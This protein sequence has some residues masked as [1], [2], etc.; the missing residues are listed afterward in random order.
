MSKNK[1]G[2]E[3]YLEEVKGLNLHEAR[4]ASSKIEYL[5][6]FK[7]IIL[8]LKK[9]F[10]LKN[11]PMSNEEVITLVLDQKMTIKSSKAFDDL[12]LFIAA[13][14]DPEIFNIDNLMSDWKNAGL[15]FML[16]DQ[17]SGN[18]PIQIAIKT[19]NIGF[20]KKLSDNGVKID[21]LNK[22]GF[23][24]FHILVEKVRTGDLKENVVK[25]W[26][27]HKLP[28]NTL[29]SYQTTAFDN[30]TVDLKN[31]SLMKILAEAGA[32]VDRLDSNG[33]NLLHKTLLNNNEKDVIKVLKLGANPNVA[34]AKNISPILL[35]DNSIK[36]KIA[37]AISE[38]NKNSST[39]DYDE[40]FSNQ[41]LESLTF[42]YEISKEDK[43][44]QE[45]FANYIKNKNLINKTDSKLLI[46]EFHILSEYLE[47]SKKYSPEETLKLLAN[48]KTKISDN[49][50]DGLL[51][52]IANNV[53]KENELKYLLKTFTDS[54]RKFSELYNK[55]SPIHYATIV[56]NV[57]FLKIAL[58]LGANLSTRDAEGMT[59]IHT[60]VFMSTKDEKFIEIIKQWV[61]FGLSFDVTDKNGY[62]AYQ[63]AV[64]LD[65]K[66][67]VDIFDNAPKINT[68]L[69]SADHL[70]ESVLSYYYKKYNIKYSG[71]YKD[72]DYKDSKHDMLIHYLVHNS[73]ANGGKFPNNI[74]ESFIK[75][76]IPTS[77][78]AKTFSNNDAASLTALNLLFALAKNSDNIG[79]DSSSFD[80]LIVSFAKCGVGSMNMDN[81]TTVL[82]Y[83]VAFNRE[84]LIYKLK[85]IKEVDFNKLDQSE[86]PAIAQAL[87]QCKENLVKALT[88][89]GADLNLQPNK[90]DPTLLH[91]LIENNMIDSIKLAIKYGATI[92]NKSIE[93]AKTYGL[94]NLVNEE[95]LKKHE[96]LNDEK[97]KLLKEIHE[98]QNKI[99]KEYLE[100]VLKNINS[101][102]SEKYDNKKLD[103]LLKSFDNLSI[104][105]VE[106]LGD[107]T[108]F[109]S[110]F[111][112]E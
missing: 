47:K 88:E 59:A 53:T 7:I 86:S 91:L 77:T 24:P 76:G 103:D 97:K 74:I 58:E 79:R 38:Y 31:Y 20:I 75:K 5:D 85:N 26:I 30:L 15:D 105:E 49:T 28:I 44:L 41:N 101:G 80:D 48:K 62:S 50:F 10:S 109:N 29:S 56:K 100:F 64:T 107:K 43:L 3:K 42:T 8:Y 36:I 89:N 69:L 22:D 46:L 99:S 37:K 90:N 67:V 112:E 40:I 14:I 102:F 92:D 32:N 1:S 70:M 35:A 110:E 23:A 96:L 57:E 81:K 52:F 16:K 83:A 60:L 55:F 13:N 34:T 94:E 108:D 98:N 93:L 95:M 63:Y 72:I 45:S 19:S 82:H 39:I 27:K 12:M 73:T 2:F 17:I 65:L 71:D 25:E 61:K 111:I 9:F 106:N 11:I 6:E 87:V 54:G 33:F 18:D 51:S 104:M 66:K 21:I 84:N 68:D 4:Q 78:L